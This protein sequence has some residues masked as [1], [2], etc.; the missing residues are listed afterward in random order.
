MYPYAL[1]E[2]QTFR[3]EALVI[4]GAGTTTVRLTWTDNSEGEDSFS[5]ERDEDGG[6]FS[7][8][9]TVAAETETY[10]D[11]VDEGHTYTYRVRA[12]SA[13]KGDSEYTNEAEVT[14]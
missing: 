8:I 6:G 5:I 13:A 14:V 9:D 12:I 1:W 3:L 11:T 2:M 4:G 10:D 7:E